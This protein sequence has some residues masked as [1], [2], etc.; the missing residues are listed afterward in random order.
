MIE[1]ARLSPSAV[2]PL[3]RI[4]VAIDPAGSVGE[5]SD[6]TAIVVAGV[7]DDGLG[8]VLDAVSSKWLPPQWAQKAISLYHRYSADRIVAERNFGG[9]MVES[10]IRAVD[11]S[12]SFRAVT[13]SRGKL[14]RAE[15]IAAL[16]EQNRVRIAGSFPQMEDELCSYCGTGKS[17]NLLDAMV[18]ALTD[19]MASS[20][21][22]GMI[23]FYRR[24]CE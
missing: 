12:V 15:P 13:A 17:P 14:V 24:Q 8:Y 21:N 18:W 22:D 19:L 6:E 11:S 5:D 1:R 4:V 3:Q 2:P 23:E 9:D 16:Y 7:A 20:R 10:T